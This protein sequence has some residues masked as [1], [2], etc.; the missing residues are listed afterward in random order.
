MYY[1]I[2]PGLP[3]PTQ[4]G[5]RA[6]DSAP[7]VLETNVDWH[8]CRNYAY[9]PPA[10]STHKPEARDLRG[11][12]GYRA[13]RGGGVPSDRTPVWHPRS[14]YLSSDLLISPSPACL[15]IGVLHSSLSSLLQLRRS[16][17]GRLVSCLFFFGVPSSS[18]TS[19]RELVRVPSGKL[20]ERVR[21]EECQCEIVK[22][23]LRRVFL[24]ISSE[25]ISSARHL[26]DSLTNKGEIV[27]TVL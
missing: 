8:M 25:C 14:V 7:L 6:H 26:L 17:N 5:P 3:R 27:H 10:L 2:P 11:F 18:R 22:A 15:S 13:G 9:S 16:K 12:G 20:R 1:P 4:S 19:S 21:C 24:Y 23:V